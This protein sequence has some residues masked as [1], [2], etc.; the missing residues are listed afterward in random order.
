[1]TGK[2]MKH[3]VEDLR[4]ILDYN[5]ETGVLTWR[6]KP[7]PRGMPQS[8]RTDIMKT[9]GDQHDRHQPIRPL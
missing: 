3:T 9:T 6:M 1:M 4:R 7:A 8:E 2:E 5:P